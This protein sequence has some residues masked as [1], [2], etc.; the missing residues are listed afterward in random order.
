MTRHVHV[1]PVGRR[2]TRLPFRVLPALFLAYNA[3]PK[4]SGK[5]HSPVKQRWLDGDREVGIACDG[6]DDDLGR[7]NPDVMSLV[8]ILSVLFVIAVVH[9]Y[10]AYR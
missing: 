7:A 4:D 5:V 2:Y 9:E 6:N 1:V 10:N 8:S 3:V